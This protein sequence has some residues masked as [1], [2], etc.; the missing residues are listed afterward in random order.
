MAKK[1][2]VSIATEYEY[3]VTKIR[4]KTGKLRSSRGNG[5]AVA[6]AMLVH[7]ANGG[8]MDSIINANKLADRMKPHAKKAEGLKRM[9]LGVMLRALVRNGTPVKIGKNVVE[10]L[11]Q[12]VEMPKVEK[13]ATSA[14]KAKRAGKAK[15]RRGA[16]KTARAKAERTTRRARKAKES[17]APNSA[18]ME[19]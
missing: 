2:A 15:G 18:P 1:E 12:K 14:P 9:T 16:V 8:D 6:N 3:G 4:D 13:T 11:N 5:D 19:V 10:K 17:D 7:R